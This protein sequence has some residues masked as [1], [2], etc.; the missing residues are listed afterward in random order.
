MASI[1]AMFLMASSRATGTSAFSRTA[2]GPQAVG[3]PRAVA[4]CRALA[5]MAFLRPMAAVLRTPH[6]S[7]LG[8]LVMIKADNV[9]RKNNHILAAA[10]GSGAIL[11]GT[12]FSFRQG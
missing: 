4:A 12:I 5:G 6:R 9:F 10:S 3:M 1:T 11:G 8:M 2:F 7:L